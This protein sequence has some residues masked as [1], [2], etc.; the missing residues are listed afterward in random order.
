MRRDWWRF[1]LC[2]LCL[3]GNQALFIVGLGLSTPVQASIWQPSQ[4][5]FTAVIASCIGWEKMDLQKG[6]GIALS[7]AGAA[8]MV[9]YGSTA[10]DI[11]ASASASI[12]FFFNCLGTSLYVIFSKPLLKRYPALSVTGWSYI[13]ASVGMGLTSLQYVHEAGAWHVPAGAWAALAYWVIMAS[14]VAYFLMTWANQ[15]ADASIVSAYTTL[16]PLT[17]GVLQF[18]F[19]KKAPELRDLGGIGV[20]AG[21]LMVVCSKSGKRAHAPGVGTGEADSDGGGD[22]DGGEGGEGK[23]EL[24][25]AADDDGGSLGPGAPSAGAA[26]KSQGDLEREPLVAGRA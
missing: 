7:V 9:S 24:R 1:L 16:Q 8:F 12:C 6:V 17:S 10:A 2:G 20:L 18:V 5:I 4:P 21:M 15:Y 25:G 13:V 14:I 19:L 22:D 3:Y 23:R 26:R 11:W